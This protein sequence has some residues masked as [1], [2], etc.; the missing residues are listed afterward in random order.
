MTHRL[1]AGSVAL[2]IVLVWAAAVGTRAQAPPQGPSLVDVSLAGQ[3]SF[4]RYC[5]A[6]HGP[7]GRGDG[8]VA[9]ELRTRP[10]DLTTLARRNDG[11]YPRDRVRDYI[12]GTGR[13]PAAHGTTEM[14]IWG[15]LFRAFES[16]TR[17]RVRVDNLVSYVES[18]QAPST[19][20][21]DNGSALFRAY[22]SP[23][24]GVDARGTGPVAEHLR[25]P[26]PDLT[27]LAFGNGGIFPTQRVRAV[28]DGRGV[29][30]HGD[31]EM[32]VWGDAF[33]RTRGGL[34]EDAVRARIDAI[35]VYLEGIQQRAT[36]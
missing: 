18:L 8:P 26:P 16:D 1:R 7:G 2:G 13:T 10:S 24:H 22:C 31:R 36:D 4:D 9:R 32:P 29:A 21:H 14:P 30:S 35:V 11:A 19:A 15:P 23:C 27:Q 3:D 20:V 34:D 25:R 28:V 6:C 5:A 33:K 12:V 17:V